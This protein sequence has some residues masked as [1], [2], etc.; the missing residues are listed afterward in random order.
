MKKRFSFGACAV[1]MLI[2][3]IFTY[4]ITVISQEKKYALALDS[5]SRIPSDDPK[6]AEAKFYVENYFIKEY[7]EDYVSD[8]TV[9]GYILGLKDPHSSYY[10][11]EQFAE[12]QDTAN[13]SA[14]GIG[15]RI[16]RNLTT[17]E[18]TVYEVIKGSPAEEADI[19]KG[20]IIS[21]VNGKNYSELTFEGAYNE[22][23]GNEGESVDI[24]LKR[25]EQYLDVKITRRHFEQQTV[26]YRLCETDSKI[27]YIRI[28]SFDIATTDQ[29]KNA[30]ESLLEMGA[31]S[32][33]FDVRSNPG[34]TLDSVSKIL[35]YLLP[36]GPIIRMVDKNGNSDIIQS[37]SAELSAP[38]AVIANSS[39]ASA[40]ELFTSALMDYSKATF[41]GTKTYGKGT[42]QSS[43]KLSDG[44]GIRISTQY[45]LPPFSPSFDGIGIE[46]DIEVELSERSANLY[47][48]LPET[49]DEQ[50]YAAIKYLQQ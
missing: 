37:D 29:F 48:I 10:T 31:V 27:G 14:T 38:M 45:Y 47:Y 49:E 42:V 25:G 5:V 20:D 18:M 43:Y 6:L 8:A 35:D 13:G 7:D 2:A 3:A 15:I 16:F 40:A 30:V 24:T 4:Q 36:A 32:F 39:S 17:D 19:R 41:I 33:I 34:G 9:L 11:K 21:A 1:L 26:S 44:S 46:P 28:H 50:L 23:L 22:L 12:F